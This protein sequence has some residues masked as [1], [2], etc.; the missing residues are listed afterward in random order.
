MALYNTQN[1]D[2]FKSK[3]LDSSKLVLVDFWASWC[4]PCIAMAPVLEQVSKEM[5]SIID[6]VKVNVEDS[7]DN[8]MLANQYGVQGIP[9]MQIFRNGKVVKTLVGMRPYEILKREIGEAVLSN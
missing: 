3:V 9:N 2:G 8:A 4:G 5:D 7:Q 6:V 1:K